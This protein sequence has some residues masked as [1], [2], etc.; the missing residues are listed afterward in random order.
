MNENDFIIKFN[1]LDHQPFYHTYMA[2]DGTNFKYEFEARHH[3]ITVCEPKKREEYYQSLLSNRNWF[4]R[5]LNMK[6]SMKFYDKM[7]F[8]SL[9]K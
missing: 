4:E 7:T 2:S 6:P 5:L 8:K 3:E 1:G 9:F